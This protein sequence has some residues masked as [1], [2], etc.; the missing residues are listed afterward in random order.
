MND[1]VI[2]LPIP[3][4]VNNLFVNAAKGKGRYPSSKYT[5]WKRD[6]QAAIVEQVCRGLVLPLTIQ[7]PV[8]LQIT[9]SEKCR[10]DLD[11]CAKAVIDFIVAQGIIL[12]DS[13]RIVRKVCL[14]WGSVSACEVRIE[15][16]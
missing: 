14:A 7:R 8:N 15:Q 4:S 1:I 6:A 16:A 2:W 5:R 13:K 10:S 12:D 3:P 11:N 9:I